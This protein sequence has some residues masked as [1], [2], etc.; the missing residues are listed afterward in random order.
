MADYN[1]LNDKQFGWVLLFCGPLV[2]SCEFGK[3]KKGY[4]FGERKSFG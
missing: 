2:V 4:R 3:E 1:N